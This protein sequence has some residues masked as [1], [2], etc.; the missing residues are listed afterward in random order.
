MLA[1][2]RAG[3]LDEW[4][5]YDRIEPFGDEQLTR[6]FLY[7]ISQMGGER[8]DWETLRRRPPVDPDDDGGPTLAETAA[9]VMAAFGA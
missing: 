7:A 6:L 9:T 1:G 4:V 3:L 5:A 2:M 8:V